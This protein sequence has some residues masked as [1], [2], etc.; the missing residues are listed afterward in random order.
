MTFEHIEFNA[1]HP[2]N[3]FLP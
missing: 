3:N 1:I 2:C